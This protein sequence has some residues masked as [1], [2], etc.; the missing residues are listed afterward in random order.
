[1][2]QLIL[3]G[4]VVTAFGGYTATSGLVTSGL[5][6][7]MKIPGETATQSNIVKPAPI[8]A[9]DERIAALRIPP[10]LKLEKFADGL[11]SP[12]VIVVGA[13][14][15]IYV[16]SR[17]QGTISLLQVRNGKVD[18]ARTVLTKPNVH[19][20]AIKDGRLFYVTIREIFSSAINPDG[21]L[22][23][24]ARIAGDLPDAGQHPNRTI[25]FGPDGL[26]YASVG[27]TCNDCEENNPESATL[28]RMKLDGT[29]REVVASGLRNTIG[30]AWQPGTDVL[31][32]LDNGVDTFGDDEQPEELNRIEPGRKYGWPYILGAGMKHPL[33]EPK[34][35]TLDDWDKSSVR[36]VLTYTAHAASMQLLFADRTSLPVEY[37]G[38]A[39]ATMHG[40]W[41]RKPPSGYE[42]V[43]IRFE[44]GQPRSIEP[45]VSG[46]LLKGSDGKWGR[47]ARP[48]GLAVAADG[49]LILGDEQNGVLYRISGVAH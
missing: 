28:I 42:V 22:G 39:F 43:R 44:N 6:Q 18:S 9:T 13:G 31:Y 17:D 45:F 2:R 24:E 8:E 37:R 7:G 4:V 12:R 35:G 21:S 1:V 34:S 14:G 38:D 36:P 41:N 47:F 40:S 32:G 15:D 29:G 27:S 26:L 25:A 30:F 23:A 19:G 11:K 48:F 20:M 5:A 10:G 33:R 3:T 16:S 49:S 46:F